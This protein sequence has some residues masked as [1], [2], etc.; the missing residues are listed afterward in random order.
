MTNHFVNFSTVF[1]CSC[2]SVETLLYIHT[3]WPAQKIIDSRRISLRM[4]CN[5]ETCESV[6]PFFKFKKNIVKRELLFLLAHMRLH[7]DEDLGFLCVC[8]C[9]LLATAV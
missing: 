4:T 5:F 7:M 2:P 9:E 8:A 3:S 6:R 1:F